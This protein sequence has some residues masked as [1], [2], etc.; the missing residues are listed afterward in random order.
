MNAALFNSL[1]GACNVYIL[2]FCESSRLWRR[3]ALYVLIFLFVIGGERGRGELTD[4]GMKRPGD[5]CLGHL[6]HREASLRFAQLQLAL[7]CY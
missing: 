5:F 2:L 3:S 6:L 1:P 7:A 4:M